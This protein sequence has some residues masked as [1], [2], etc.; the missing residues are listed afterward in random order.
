MS[1]QEIAEFVL[2]VGCFSA[3]IFAGAA[4]LAEFLDWL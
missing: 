2:M 3:I 1:P 4:L